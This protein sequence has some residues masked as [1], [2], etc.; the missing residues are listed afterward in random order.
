MAP[1][2]FPKS[3]YESLW[4]LMCPIDPYLCIMVGPYVS[5][6]VFRYPNGSWWILIEH[7]NTM[8][9]FFLVLNTKN[10]SLIKK[11]LNEV[12]PILDIC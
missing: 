12:P 2:G 5:L 9:V 1:K 6:L 4:V 10:S 7:I 3:I 11:E 8:E